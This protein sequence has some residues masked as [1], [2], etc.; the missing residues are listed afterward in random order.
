[1]VPSGS[2]VGL[3]AGVGSGG[4]TKGIVPSGSGV[5]MGESAGNGGGVGRMV[6]GVRSGLVGGV[7]VGSGAF[8]ETGLLV[9]ASAKRAVAMQQKETR[10]ALRVFTRSMGFVY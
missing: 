3:K 4:G 6:C 10:Q 7:G 2:G 9:W 5:G 8:V 1:M